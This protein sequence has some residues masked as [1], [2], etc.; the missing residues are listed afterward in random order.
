MKYH[1]IISAGSEL[2]EISL[3]ESKFV[4]TSVSLNAMCYYMLSH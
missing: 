1:I 2:G 3:M 4:F